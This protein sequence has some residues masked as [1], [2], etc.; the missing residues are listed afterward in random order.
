MRKSKKISTELRVG[1]LTIR[2]VSRAREARTLAEYINVSRART[3]QFEE[4]IKNIDFDQW[5]HAAEERTKRELFRYRQQMAV[6]EDTLK[7]PRILDRVLHLMTHPY[8]RWWALEDLA[9]LI[10]STEKTVSA[11]IRELRSPKYGGYTVEVRKLGKHQY[12]IVRE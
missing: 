8:G 11:R 7:L 10:G 3:D 9:Y 12:R 1:G 6:L 4:K 5:S 2:V